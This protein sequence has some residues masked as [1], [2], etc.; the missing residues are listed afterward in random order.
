MIM[1]TKHFKLNA[2]IIS[3]ATVVGKKE[4]EGPLGAHF[5]FFSLDD[6]YGQNTWEASESEMQRIALSYAMRKMDIME[7]DIDLMFAGDL[8]NQCVGSAYGLLSYDIPYLG[9]Y[10]ACST[11]AESLLLAASMVTAG[12]ADVTAAVTSSHNASAERQFRYPVEYGGQRPPTAQWT[13][14]G[15][16]AFLVTS[17]EKKCYP[18]LAYVT[19]GMPGI[20]LIWV[21]TTW[22][23]WARPWP[24]TLV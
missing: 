24:L 9:L 16:G 22:A 19:A 12:F 7:N 13:V 1:K 18:P 11:C 8:L 6:R 14:T 10:G 3:A 21:S 2:A 15:S 23:I 20:V 4:H 5:D 17:M